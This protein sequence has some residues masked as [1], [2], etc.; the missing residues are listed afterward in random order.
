VAPGRELAA[1]LEVVEHLSRGRRLDVYDAW[2]GERGCRCVVKAVRP[3]RAGERDVREALLREGD[4]LA[5]LGHPHIVRAYETVVDPGP[6]VVM[7][8]L[9]G[10]TLEYLLAEAEEPAAPAAVAHLGL[11]LGSAIRYLHRH[12]VLHL[13]LKPGNVV[14]D[15]GLAKLIDLSVARPSGPCPP[16][17][18]TWGYMAP[19][20]ALGDDVGPAADI[21]GLGVVLFE[22]AAGRPAFDDSAYED[23]ATSADRAG[24]EGAPNPQ[25][26]ERAVPLSE[27]RADLPVDLT[28]LVDRCLEPDPALRPPVE[29]LLGALEPIAGTPVAERRWAVPRP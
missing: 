25:V 5:R 29:A 10:E 6:M 14:A 16:E 24:G 17:V 26:S 21:W 7:E 15:R 22:V 20:Q 1:G 12:R 8:T 9:P 27:A 13:D 11:H 3:D 2:S 18:G 4:L 19:E 23:P 28:E